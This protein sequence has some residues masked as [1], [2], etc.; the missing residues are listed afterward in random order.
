MLQ[1][2][3][4]KVLF[5]LLVFIIIG[6]GSLYSIISVSYEKMAI[7]EGSK[8]VQMLGDS[9]FQT[10]RMSMNIGTREA[11]D[12]GL[13]QASKIP[14]VISLEIH[15]SQNVIDLFG[16]QA[17]P[18]ER[19]DIQEVFKFAKPR[20][21]E[22]NEDNKHNITFQKP[23]I[24]D[25]SC[26][27]CHQDGILKEGD[28]LGVLELKVSMESLYEEMSKNETYLLLTMITAGILA[29][30]GLYIFFEKELIKPL[31]QLRDMAR[32]LTEGESGDLTRRI[33]IK[34]ND[35]VGIVS[36][37]VNRFIQT[38]QDTITLSK[39][40]SGENTQISEQLLEISNV[41]SKNS[42]E[43]FDLMDKVNLVAQNVSEK[44]NLVEQMANSTTSDIEQTEEIL[45]EFVHHLQDS[46]GLIT[47]SAQTQQGIS[48]RVEA[49][50]Q[51]A[52]QITSVLGLIGDIADQTNL[53][54]LNAAIEAARAGEHGRGFA[55]VA[56][57]VRSLAE[58][59]QKS[60]NEISTNVNLVT[61]SIEDMGQTI[62]ESATEMV[63][64]A[65]NTTPLVEGAHN[66]KEK[67]E[68]TK[69]NSLK[70]KEISISIAQSTK[71]LTQMMQEI[72]TSSEL[73]QSV[74]H[75]IQGV[76]NEMSQKAQELD[77]AIAKFK[78]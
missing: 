54:A 69:Q 74:G 57:E 73:T 56:D 58:R 67:L 34:R 78:T 15:K 30:F 35:E 75:N 51:H 14:G 18:S 12:D 1:T 61:Q 22:L 24:A 66:T 16:M 21:Q 70:L 44:L 29:I 50:T 59:T 64:I 48:E 76:V 53:L 20:L 49:L 41:L 71:A 32:D 77:N 28:V 45:D 13:K 10:V 60:L 47:T 8:T 6:F 72:T 23:L 19:A 65:E 68:T 2:F 42:D 3:R 7:E 33:A 25:N 26:L 46:I 38:I 27:T 31:N 52:A 40:V 43:Q 63:H 11:I 36:S 37:Y 9:I 4:S 17:K 5:T 39:R 55:V 62:K